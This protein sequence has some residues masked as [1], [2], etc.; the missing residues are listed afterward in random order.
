MGL[1]ETPIPAG[2][3]DTSPFNNMALNKSVGGHMLPIDDDYEN[4][5]TAA[6]ARTEPPQGTYSTPKKKK[7]RASSSSSRKDKR[8]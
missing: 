2:D 7:A 3:E 1:V 5:A 8:A 6:A 4:A